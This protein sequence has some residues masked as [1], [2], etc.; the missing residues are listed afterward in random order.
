MT[1][2]KTGLAVFTAMLV[3][4]AWVPAITHARS[5]ASLGDL[6]ASASAVP[7][8]HPLDHLPVDTSSWT[9]FDVTSL[10]QA[11]S[12]GCARATPND[13]ADDAAAIACFMNAVPPRSIVHLRAGTYNCH[14]TNGMNSCFDLVKSEQ[15][16]RGDGA[17]QTVITSSRSHAIMRANNPN[18]RGAS[19]S[20]TGGF[21]RGSRVLNVSSTASFSDGAWVELR[22]NVDPE[23]DAG[24]NATYN[25]L[26]YFAVVTCAGGAGSDCTGTGPGQ[27]RIDRPLRHD[28]DTGGQSATVWNPLARAGLEDLTLR[29]DNPGTAAKDASGLWILDVADFWFR[30]V[31]F[32]NG[33]DTVLLIW[34][35]ARVLVEGC[36]FGLLARTSAWQKASV[37]IIAVHDSEFVN[38]VWSNAHVA[39]QVSGLSSGD[40]VAY[41]RMY[42]PTAPGFQWCERSFFIHGGPALELLFEGND[43]ECGLQ[44]DGLQ[45]PAGHRVVLYRNRGRVAGTSYSASGGGNVA[46]RDGSLVYHADIPNEPWRTQQGWSAQSVLRDWL[47]AGNSIE[48]L[49]QPVDLAG[50][51]TNANSQRMLVERN[52]IR[53]SCALENAATFGPACQDRAPGATSPNSPQQTTWSSNELGALV[54][55]SSWSTFAFPSSLAYPGAPGWWCQE[56]GAF[57]GIG[58]PSDDFGSPGTLGRLPAEIRFTGGTCTPVAESGVPPDAPILL[59]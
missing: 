36:E 12:L 4:V 30:G 49:G 23:V 57:P 52:V 5:Q 19:V 54:A 9:V 18:P 10:P 32:E 22:A 41:N 24:Q 44:W 11:S 15:V 8:W 56:A 38:N 26:S 47:I 33:L 58:A 37:K 42:R 21:T 28:F 29:Y 27:I 16:L 43:F 25:E 13:G 53:S 20:W 35:G 48:H 31:E 59:P 14:S 34:R 55:P 40:I 17:G 1:E 3:A 7:D 6:G 46:N 45:G 39:F 2:R 50:W 51:G